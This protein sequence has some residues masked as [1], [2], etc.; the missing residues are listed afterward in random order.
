MGALEVVI[1]RIRPNVFLRIY[2]GW[3]VG[4]STIGT[5]CTVAGFLLALTAP[6]QLNSRIIIIIIT[7]TLEIGIVAAYLT[8]KQKLL[9]DTIIDELSGENRYS[10]SFCSQQGLQEADEMTKPLFDRGFIPFDRIEQWRLKNEKGFVQI[11]NSDGVLCACFVI[12]GLEHSFLDQFIAGRVDEHDIDSTVVLPFDSMR[13]EERIYIS[14]VV[15]REP[16]SYMGRKRATIMLWSILQYIKRTFK[17]QKTRTFY[18][19]GLTRESERLLQK[20]GFQICCDKRSRKDDS[21]LYR[22]D[23][24]QKTWT[25]LLTRIGDFSKMV[26]FDIGL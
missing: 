5:L 4:I 12:L 9:P 26:F 17:L 21:N 14:G 2:N 13:R 10:V 24:D 7:A 3:K 6:Q 16:G 1:K 11:N 25:E 18:A 8:G 22:I 19:V 15:V 23:L 20:L